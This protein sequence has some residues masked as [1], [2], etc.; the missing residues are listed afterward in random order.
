MS[1]FVADTGVDDNEEAWKR[2]RWPFRQESSV[3]GAAMGLFFSL[4]TRIELVKRIFL[5]CC[6]LSGLQGM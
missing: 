4:R 6:V 5:E 2:D 3:L 1:F